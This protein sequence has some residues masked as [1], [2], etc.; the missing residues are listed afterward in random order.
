MTEQQTTSLFALIKLACI[1]S[2]IDDVRSEATKRGYSVRVVQLDG[3]KF[4]TKG[5]IVPTRINV[6]VERGVVTDVRSLG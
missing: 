3:E 2:S 1:G 4:R 5:N 6:V